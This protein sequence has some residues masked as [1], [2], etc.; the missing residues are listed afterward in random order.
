VTVRLWDDRP[1]GTPA[2]VHERVAFTVELNA[3]ASVAVSPDGEALAVGG[4]DGTVRVWSTSSGGEPAVFRGHQGPITALTF[5]A[6][7]SFLASADGAG[8]LKVR[9]RI[10][11]QEQVPFEGPPRRVGRVIRLAFAPDGRALASGSMDDTVTLWDLPAGT[12]RATFRHGATRGDPGIVLLLFSPD[13]KKLA[14]GNLGAVQ[15]RDARTGE[16]RATLPV[17][18]GGLTSVVFAPDSNTLAWSRAWERTVTLWD[19]TA[20]RK[21][22]TL[23]GH[24]GF[25]RA[26]AFSPDGRTLAS[27]SEDTSVSLWDVATGKERALLPGPGGRVHSVAFSADGRALAAGTDTGGVEV[28]EAR[29]S[30]VK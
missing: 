15:V 3:P 14:S 10:T 23:E 5:S 12:R 2:R 4:E 11:G 21:R 8:H 28:W 24:R 19:V 27:G 18:T 26:L 6:N 17:S 16:A 25:V 13:G 30:P 20:N 29:P 9:D 1:A 7:S 22:A